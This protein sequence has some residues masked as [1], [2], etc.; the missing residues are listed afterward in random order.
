M[1]RGWG[2]LLALVLVL[3]GLACFTICLAV[4][5]QD[6]AALRQA[7]AQFETA[8]AGG[9]LRQVIVAD[10]QQNVFRINLFADVVWALL[11][12]LIAAVGLHGIAVRPN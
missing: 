9:T 11:G 5:F 12:A 1:R 6:Y 7:Y 4:A 3:P 10:A 8:A 2:W